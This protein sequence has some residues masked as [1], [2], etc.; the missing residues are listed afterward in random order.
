MSYIVAG[1]LNA[2]SSPLRLHLMA[3]RHRVLVQ[4]L[5]SEIPI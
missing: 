2:L 3:F 4:R 5:R 1:T